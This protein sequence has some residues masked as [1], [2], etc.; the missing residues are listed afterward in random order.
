MNMQTSI[1]KGANG[2][3][4]L[5]LGWRGAFF[6]PV[7]V[8]GPFDNYEPTPGSM[9]VCVRAERVPPT[10][11]VRLAIKDFDVPQSTIAVETALKQALGAALGGR[12]V[13]VGCM[14]GWGRTGLFLAL[15]AKAAGVE[16]P[17]DYVRQNYT[18]R[19]VETEQQYRYVDNFDVSNVQK[20]MYR[21][22]WEERLVQLPLIGRFF[23]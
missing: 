20:W 22:A 19:A 13:Y 10:A 18:V 5:P 3:L 7:I 1:P 14:G 23:R 16:R 2:V 8:G 12:Q 4:S 6:A 9:G 17:V 21:A 11:N 15:L